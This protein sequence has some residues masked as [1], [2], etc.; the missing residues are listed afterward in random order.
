[1]PILFLWARG[2]FWSLHEFYVMTAKSIPPRI[3]LFNGW[4]HPLHRRCIDFPSVISWRAMDYFDDI[5]KGVL[6][7]RR[8]LVDV[9]CRARSLRTG[10]VPQRNCVTKI[11]PNVRVNFLVRFASNPLFYWI[12]TGSPLELFRK[13]FGAVRANFWFCGSF[14]APEK[15]FRPKLFR[16][17]LRGMSM[18]KCLKTRSKG[19][20]PQKVPRSTF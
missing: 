17:R 1:M 10:K 11:L 6:L 2:F 4:P 5:L 12:M 16:G 13:F 14:L 9:Y 18:P 19:V 3:V 8:L 7:S 20:E 15:F